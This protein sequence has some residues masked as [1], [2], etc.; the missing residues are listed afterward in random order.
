[1]SETAPGCTS[2]R[3]GSRVQEK[4][5]PLCLRRRYSRQPRGGSTPR[6]PRRTMA[7]SSAVCVTRARGVLFSLKK[8]GGRVTCYNMDGP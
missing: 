1:M 3:T 7:K 8:G 2:K 5:A 6:V 4:S